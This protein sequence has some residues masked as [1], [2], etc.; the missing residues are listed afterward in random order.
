MIFNKRCQEMDLKI[1]ASKMKIFAT[2]N[3]MFLFEKENGIHNFKQNINSEKLEQI[4]GCACL[5]RMLIMLEKEIL[6]VDI[7][8]LVES[9]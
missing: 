5:A 6:T 2:S 4:D 8:R 1:N 9:V 3:K 7:Q